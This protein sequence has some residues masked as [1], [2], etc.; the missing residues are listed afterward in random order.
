MSS[1]TDKISYHDSGNIFRNSHEIDHVLNE[2]G[3][4]CNYDRKQETC[5]KNGCRALASFRGS[6]K[7]CHFCYYKCCGFCFDKLSESNKHR[8]FRYY[9]TNCVPVY[10][11]NN[12]NHNKEDLYVEVVDH[13]GHI[14]MSCQTCLHIYPDFSIEIK[15]PGYD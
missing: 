2:K 5:G 11:N 13:N 15:D 1:P 12:L 8:G 10:C 6:V 3:F 14:Y 7:F 4:G 9:C